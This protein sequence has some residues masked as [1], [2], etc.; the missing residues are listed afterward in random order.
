MLDI[1]L[2]K[3]IT[4]VLLLT[5][6]IVFFRFTWLFYFS[7][8]SLLFYLSF[9]IFCICLVMLL[10]YLFKPG[11][12]LYVSILALIFSI[13][14]PGID[15][16]YSYIKDYVNKP[17]KIIYSYKEAK[18]NRAAFEK[19]WNYVVYQWANGPQKS[20]EEPDKK[21]ILPFVLK[22]NSK[23]RFFDSTIRINNL[24]FRGKD[25][26]ISKGNCFRIV[27]IGESTTAG[28]TIKPSDRP[29]PEVL[30]ELVNDLSPD[31][32]KCIEVINAGTVA[33]DLKDNLERVR[34]DIIPLNPD[35]IICYHGFNGLRHLQAELLPRVKKR[36]P[37]HSS[38]ILWD[39]EVKIATLRA[40]KM[41]FVKGIGQPRP[42]PELL[43]S[44]YAELYRELIQ[45]GRTHKFAIALAPFN[46]AVTR[47]SPDDVIGFYSAGFPEVR[48]YISAIED[49]N[50]L[51]E[52][53]AH[54]E[55]ALFLEV[56][57]GINGAYDDDIFVDLV[58][59]TQKGR[60]MMAKAIFQELKPFLISTMV[61]EASAGTE[62]F[63][64][65]QKANA[66]R[67]MPFE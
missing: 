20:I 60:D 42:L 3:I 17:D 59:F 36:T 37:E 30:Q 31:L 27:V 61:R 66:K 58:H 33:Y 26:S 22:P 40:Q 11:I 13:L 25:I 5:S 49:H 56:R 64:T 53:L 19:W 18:G 15:L 8:F 24:G 21:G 46:M 62:F 6:I 23:A 14:L 38:K 50:V 47:E 10:Y 41:P 43:K 54:N 52:A 55:G 67:Q 48:Q 29:W 65:S 2:R 35:L 16:L 32:G 44:Q 1:K 39:V 57:A 12:L 9:I 7:G 4:V 51:V 45:M 34:R 28:C 63:D